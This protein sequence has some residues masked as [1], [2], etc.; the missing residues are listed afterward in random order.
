VIATPRNPHA[1]R[2]LWVDDQWEAG[3]VLLLEL[4][5]FT[6]DCATT[7]ATGLSMAC[8]RAYDGIVP[9]ANNECD[10]LPRKISVGVGRVR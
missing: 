8:A 5:G 2:V 7:V 4:E 10:N 1:P 6:G 3:M 9:R